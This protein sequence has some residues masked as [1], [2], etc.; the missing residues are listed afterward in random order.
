MKKKIEDYPW[1]PKLVAKKD[2][3]SLRELSAE[4]GASPAAISNAL[5]RNNLSRESA[6]SGPKK[7]RKAAA[8]T[9][10]AA[11]KKAAPK[12]AA[13][14][15]AAPKKAA[16]KKAAPKKAAPKKAAPKKAAPKKAAPKKAAPKKA[17]PRKAAPKARPVR[18][19]RPAKAPSSRPARTAPRKRRISVL[20][21]YQDQMGKVVDREIA[22]KAGVTVSAVTNYRKRHNIPPATGRGR[23]RRSPGAPSVT[24]S[25]GR[26]R[27]SALA[28]QVMVGGDVLVVV[29]SNIVEAA[30]RASAA[31][32]GDVTR[33]ELIGPAMT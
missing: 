20:E 28:F 1:W 16:P 9:K 17:A 3:K 21:K 2:D 10:K 8:T 18:K 13:P 24:R 32:R 22:E 27:T 25:A 11:P 12:K 19:T 6:Q 7:Y 14:K 4:F 30:Q 29:A 26:R 31:G 15:K 5:K 33:I 23:P